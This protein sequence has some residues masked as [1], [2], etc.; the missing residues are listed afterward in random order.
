[1]RT[2]QS[3]VGNIETVAAPIRSVKRFFTFIAIGCVRL[4]IFD[5]NANPENSLQ[6]LFDNVAICLD[7]RLSVGESLQEALIH[8]V[9]YIESEYWGWR[10]FGRGRGG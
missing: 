1:M 6:P 8:I 9:L 4:N 10:R 7:I 5:S 3:I 2:A